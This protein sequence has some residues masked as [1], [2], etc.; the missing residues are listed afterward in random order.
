MKKFNHINNHFQFWV[1]QIILFFSV[2]AFTGYN[3]KA[4]IPISTSSQ[5]ELVLSKKTISKKVISLK[6][7]I[8][9]LATAFVFAEQFK[10]LKVDLILQQQLLMV[11]FKAGFQ[12]FISIKKLVFFFP[13]RIISSTS[14]LDFP[15]FSIQ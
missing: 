4:E 5:T 15:I 11:K 14:D 12:K 3:A 13:K 1:I 7:A 6:K 9:H 8:S 10:F 2:F